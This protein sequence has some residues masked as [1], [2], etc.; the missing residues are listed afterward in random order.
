MPVSTKQT[1][2][3]LN[4][5]KSLTHSLDHTW[6]FDH[7]NSVILKAITFSNALYRRKLVNR[8]YYHLSQKYNCK[9]Y[10]LKKP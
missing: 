6:S 9:A 8:Y 1:R 7:T 2:K 5:M 3:S 4:R 10:K